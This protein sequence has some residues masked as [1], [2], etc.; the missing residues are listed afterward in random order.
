MGGEYSIILPDD[1]PL[2]V[3]TQQKQQIIKK[4]NNSSHNI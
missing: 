1:I 4:A 3:A 2:L